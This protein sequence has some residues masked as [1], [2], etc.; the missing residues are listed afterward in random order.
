MRG[1]PF[2]YRAS[3]ISP[4]FNLA[5]ECE[6]VVNSIP[7]VST[8]HKS[9]EGERYKFMAAMLSLSFYSG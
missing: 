6:E 1:I 3:A 4:R 2:S 9:L 8:L 5:I 7:L